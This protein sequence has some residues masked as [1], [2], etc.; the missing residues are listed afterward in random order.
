MTIL[1]VDANYAQDNNSVYHTMSEACDNAKPGDKIIVKSS[2]G[3]VTGDEIKCRG[4]LLSPIVIEGEGYFS[5][6][7]IKGQYL[8]ININCDKMY[9]TDCLGVSI[10]C[11]KV[12]RLHAFNVAMVTISHL[13]F[14]SIVMVNG[15]SNVIDSCIGKSIKL[16]RCEHSILSYNQ[17]E[18]VSLTGDDSKYR[19]GKMISNDVKELTILNGILD[20]KVNENNA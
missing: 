13:T 2:N 20:I 11:S 9:L 6:L 3:T 10:L 4:S 12:D 14:N 18:Y 7:H 16:D 1:Y 8:D 5:A 17:A 19:L 15:S